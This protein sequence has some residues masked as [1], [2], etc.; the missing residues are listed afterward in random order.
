M[1]AMLQKALSKYPWDLQIRLILADAL[2][3]NSQKTRALRIIDAGLQK[4]PKNE[5]LLKKRNQI[6]SLAGLGK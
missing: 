1:I 3:V 5:E 2:T 4:L 6:E